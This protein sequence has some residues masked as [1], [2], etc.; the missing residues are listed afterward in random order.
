MDEETLDT[1][2]GTAIDQALNRLVGVTDH[3][4]TRKDLVTAR[5]RAPMAWDLT[6]WTIHWESEDVDP[7]DMDIVSIAVKALKYTGET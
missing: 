1:G 5:G 4:T 3:Q 7:G 2:A 6:R